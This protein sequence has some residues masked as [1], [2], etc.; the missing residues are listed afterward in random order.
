MPKFIGLLVNFVCSVCPQTFC[1]SAG[2]FLH[3]QNFLRS[4][5]ILKGKTKFS[6]LS[7]IL[8]ICMIF[9][10]VSFAF[11]SVSA[12]EAQE[13]ATTVTILHTNDTH[14]RVISDPVATS[15]SLIGFDK[16][17]TLKEIYD[18]ILV[19]SG[20]F[21][22]G[23]PFVSKSL[24]E[25]AFALMEMA[26]Y[27]VVT[28]GNHEF[29][30]GCD[31]LLECL[32]ASSFRTISANVIDVETGEPFLKGVGKNAEDNNGTNYIIEKNGKKI[33]FFGLTTAET[34]NTTNPLNVNGIIRFEDETTHAKAEVA[35]LQEQGADIIICVGHLGDNEGVTKGRDIAENVAGIDIVLDGHSHD[36]INDRVIN[37][38][39]GKEVLLL[40]SQWNSL[41]V[42]KVDITFNADGTLD[43]AAENLHANS[44]LVIDVEPNAE[45]AE[46]FQE[47]NA[48][49]EEWL[50]E[51]IYGVYG[52]LFG[53][54]YN[55][56]T[57]KAKGYETNQ[58]NLVTDAYKWA[59]EN[60]LADTPE[61]AAYKDLPVV[62][63]E[64]SS[65]LR[66]S[67]TGLV[68]NNQAYSTLPFPND[69]QGKL[70][71]AKDLY[72]AL[73]CG[74]S[75]PMLS[76]IE[77]TDYYCFNNQDVDGGFPQIS[78]MSVVWDPQKTARTM[79]EELQGIE[80]VPYSGQ[81]VEEIWLLDDNGE[82]TVKLDKDDEETKLVVACH[83]F[84]AAGGN[85]YETLADCEKILSVTEEFATFVS[86]LDYKFHQA[87]GKLTYHPVSKDR[88]VIDEAKEQEIFGNYDATVT[89]F[90]NNELLTN[91]TIWV[92]QDGDSREFY[93]NDDNYVE[94]TTDENGQIT[95]KD[96]SAGV[97]EFFVSYWFGENDEVLG[98]LMTTNWVQ[99]DSMAQ[100]NFDFADNE[101][102]VEN[103]NQILNKVEGFTNKDKMDYVEFAREIYFY[104]TK[105]EKDFISD[106]MLDLFVAYQK[107][108][109][110]EE[111]YGEKETPDVPDE[112]VVPDDPAEL[113]G[114]VQ[115]DDG[116]WSYYEANVAVT[117]WKTGLPGW[118]NSWFFFDADG[119][120]A[121]GWKAD[122]PGWENSWFY[123]NPAT[124]A[125]QTNWLFVD[126]VWYFFNAS[127]VMQTGWQFI[128]N[129]WYCFATSGAMYANT[130]TPDGYT[131]DANGAWAA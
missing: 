105:S 28:L 78:G 6:V 23:T 32:N 39:T 90:Y 13:E 8:S 79:T 122:V 58:G 114:W 54:A 38:E 115:N 24:G 121:S 29:E 11:V 130:V 82:R 17:A 123:F 99:H 70:I 15:S 61:L 110:F 80:G 120:M 102:K 98:Q 45:I 95:F 77:G 33:G 9:S 26:K 116:S 37:K 71:S 96:L 22:Q 5:F 25:N 34:P 56:N 47:L 64:N 93:D 46:K 97:H 21:C 49:I 66:S 131:V 73:E 2:F 20:D 12:A 41:L 83:D 30:F 118:E 101:F 127:G 94:Y 59:V 124:G 69:I 84:L 63:I 10:S 51:I 113:N 65:G 62:A 92:A 18:A 104:M 3:F 100:I 107:E 76:K 19:D 112:P 27:D 43:I 7:Y 86:Y 87:N 109:G 40:Q 35:K 42:G 14:G 117:G 31:K 103:F 85:K 4:V 81:R 68:T 74:F 88:I 91:E 55:K 44:P 50:G 128:N 106:E 48:P 67:M 60:R 57:C 125:M 119:K 129:V 108:C 72:D 75:S 1:C 53:R 16:I 126:G 89:F 52:S 111:I 36:N